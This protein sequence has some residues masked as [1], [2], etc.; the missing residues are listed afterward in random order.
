M[1]DENKNEQMHSHMKKEYGDKMHA[2]M[3]GT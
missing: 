1:C 2:M 3:M